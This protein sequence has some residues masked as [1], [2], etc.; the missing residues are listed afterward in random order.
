LLH[1]SRTLPDYFSGVWPRVARDMIS[2]TNYYYCVCDILLLGPSFLRVR[3]GPVLENYSS[4]GIRYVYGTYCTLP[5][6][7][8]I[9]SG[10]VLL[11]DWW[12]L[13]IGFF[14]RAEMFA[15]QIII[16]LYIMKD[17]VRFHKF[18]LQPITKSR[19]CSRDKHNIGTV[20]HARFVLTMRRFTESDCV[21]FSP[22]ISIF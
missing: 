5:C 6:S 19:I 2:L 3:S 17:H 9:C 13:G 21:W 15:Y 18:Y 4:N 10:A 12:H 16:I 8:Y 11:Y 20:A 1:S 14:F 7:Y 22:E